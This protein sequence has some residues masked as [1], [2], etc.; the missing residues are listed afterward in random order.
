MAWGTS[1]EPV[2]EHDHALRL[3]AGHSSVYVLWD[4]I[5]TVHEPRDHVLAVARVAFGHHR[6]GLESAIRN[7]GTGSCLCCAFS[8]EITSAYELNMKWMHGD[9]TR[10]VWNSVVATFIEPSN[11][12]DAVRDETTCALRRVVREHL[13]A[14]CST[15][16]GRC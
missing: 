3:D 14:Q 16:G 1:G 11:R 6:H 8:A 9:N 13:T 15:S 7:V 12:S 2:H 5:T 10:F 4:D